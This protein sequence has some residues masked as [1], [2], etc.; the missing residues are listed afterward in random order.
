MLR[1]AI[2]TF[3]EGPHRKI[4]GTSF[5]VLS[6]MFVQ[7]FNFKK[8]GVSKRMILFFRLNDKINVLSYIFF[9]YVNRK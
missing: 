2:S 7:I 9:N 5:P 4:I 6:N 1:S 3:E 8:E